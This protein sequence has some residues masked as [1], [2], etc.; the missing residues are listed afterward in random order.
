ME[1]GLVGEGEGEIGVVGPEETLLERDRAAVELLGAGEVALLVGEGGE[2]A[3][4]EGDLVVVGA[5]DALE[6]GEGSL[7]GGF[8]LV[9]AAEVAEEGR[10]GATSA[11]T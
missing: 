4:I 5:V 2:V 7:V 10:V 11:A 9:V 1:D 8:G 6:D 3:E